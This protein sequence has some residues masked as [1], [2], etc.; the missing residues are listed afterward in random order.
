VNQKVRHNPYFLLEFF[1]LKFLQDISCIHDVLWCDFTI[2]VLLMVIIHI[3]RASHVWT[4]KK[5][6]E[7]P[8]P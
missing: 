5:T 6:L 7:G 1:P 8:K 2:I 4:F 3:F